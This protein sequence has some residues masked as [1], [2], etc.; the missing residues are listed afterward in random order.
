MPFSMKLWQVQ[1]R[2]LQEINR[3]TLNDEQRL[4]DWVAQDPSILGIDVLLVGRQVRTASGG[5]I[6]LL[7]IDS[8]ANLVVLE[9]KRDKTPRDVIAQA[10]DYASWVNDLSYEQIETIAT[11]FTG[12]PL[13]QAFSDHYGFSIPQTVNSSHRMV[14]LASALDD[15]SERIVTYLGEQYGVPINVL[16]FTFFKTV[17]GEFVG[18][19]W[20]KDPDEAQ[21]R[22]QARKQAPWSGY[23]FV[24][25]GEGP[26]RNWDDCRKYG[27]LSAGDGEKY[28]NA[29][30]KLKPGDVVFGYMAGLGYVG[31]GTVTQPTTMVRDFAPDGSDQKLL[32]LPLK[33]PNMS[34]N[35]DDP[36][37]SEWVVGIKWEKTFERDAAKSYKGIFAN[38][39]IVCFLRD[40]A[41]VDFLRK[42]FG[43]SA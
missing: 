4:E 9:L 13:P 43:I 24:N 5:Y 38:Q 15:S 19:A 34:N 22:T 20:L 33:Q 41:T 42:E 35:K 10:L 25:V 29:M 39:N 23:Y 16:F 18:R 7:A 1:G 17:T 36:A 2:D 30:K 14:I 21:E 8:E 37:L 26:H 40:A 12:K 11:G 28:S 31:F 32:D 27:F 3:E 6:D